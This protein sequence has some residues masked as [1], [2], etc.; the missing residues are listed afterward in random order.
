MARTSIQ[1]LK[2][3]GAVYWWR[4]KLRTSCFA[5]S[6][7]HNISLEFS[8]F[9]KE[10][11]IAR[12]RAAAMTAY[13]ER[14]RM[15]FRDN[16]RQHGLNGK[17]ISAIFVEEV[18]DYRN[19]L[20]HLEA[21]WKAHPK[22]SSVSN[23]DDDLAVFQSLWEGIAN[24]GL[25]VP[26]DWEFVERNFAQ[27]NEEMQ[28]NIRDLLR[29]QKT[30]PESLR[31][32]AQ[33]RLEMAGV[34]SN[35]VSIPV[36]VDV[37]ARARAEAARM[38][39]ENSDFHDLAKLASLAASFGEFVGSSAR[40][41]TITPPI[42]AEPNQL[43]A[44]LDEEQQNIAAMTPTE[45][46][47]VFIK[48]LFGGLENRTGGK[49][50]RQIVQELTLRDVRWVAL[51]LEKS[52]PAGTPYAQVN[53]KNV[54][55]LDA[56]FDRI[57]VTIG[58]SPWDKRP[59]T[60]FEM[61]EDRAMDRIDKGE[62]ETGQIGL[63]SNTSNKHWQNFAR[64]HAHLQTLVP[65]I[66][67]VSVKK[68]ITPEDKMAREAREKYSVEQGVAIF[69]LP[70]WTGCAGV[71]NRLSA[72]TEI[73][74]D[75][76]FFVP[77]LVWYTGARREV[78]C[79]LKLDD[80]FW[81]DVDYIYIRTTDTGRVKSLDSTRKLTLHS[82]LLRLG[83]VKYVEAMRLAGETLLFPEMYPAGGTKRAIGDVFYK[84]WWMYIRPL[85]P[86]L[87][88]GQAMHSARHTVSDALKQAGV[89]LEK[90]NDILGHS[91]KDLGEGASTYSEPLALR[92]M[93][94]TVDK[95]PCATSHLGDVLEINLLPVECRV[96]RPAREKRD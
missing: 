82:E 79:K 86:D 37:I 92:E 3:R 85:V 25:G 29:N 33:A 2:R 73:I 36:A 70:P 4:R 57:P 56:W 23:R 17:T 66:Q 78:I 95:I 12:G 15:S 42:C 28:G 10:L 13:S 32:A 51:L 59:T 52:L 18:R 7:N 53:A 35:A 47:E 77:L 9:T 11:D 50:K 69:S 74:H 19:E 91:Q 67:P 72:G 48:T 90:R 54:E 80:V 87:K 20:I 46:A 71:K 96:A 24:E 31:L 6:D 22:W 45:F 38:V 34:N 21:A 30:L 61:I 8:L 68:Y 55:N 65:G 60:T 93:K 89:E 88:R 64:M 43:A 26:R 75:A 5:F 83:F 14:L 44:P 41:S 1:N 94:D 62:L 81:N 76:L 40:A 63:S 49:R 39:R 27:F 84:I 58:K 16:V